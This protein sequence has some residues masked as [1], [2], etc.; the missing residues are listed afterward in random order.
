M[1]KVLVI[2]GVLFILTGIVGGAVTIGT[3]GAFTMTQEE[4]RELYKD[5]FK[6][7]FREFDGKLKETVIKGTSANVNIEYDS[8]DKITVEYKASNPGIYCDISFNEEKGSLYVEE[9]SIAGFLLWF[10]ISRSEITVTLPDEYKDKNIEL[11]DVYLT[12]GDLK[13]DLPK[14]E[15]LKLNFTSGKA[16]AI[17]IDCEKADLHI[18]SGNLSV[19]NRGDKMDEVEYTATSGDAKFYNFSAKESLY[20]MTSGNLYI[21][22]ATG[23]VSI[24]KTSGD[25][26]I[27]Y[28]EFDGDLQIDSTSGDSRIMLP[29]DFGFDLEFDRTSGKCEVQLPIEDSDK[30]TRITFDDDTKTHLGTDSDNS[31]KIDITSGD[32]V[33]CPVE[34]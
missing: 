12:S 29:G 33:I 26:T 19:T 4:L 1:K 20:E 6:D 24:D 11:V 5:K 3:A 17:T 21:E 27:G 8:T 34:Q 9:R 13:G 10:N 23:D 18:T 2:I 28:A 32:V 7:D 22:G 25:T 14:C 15:N 16:D 30:V 31:I